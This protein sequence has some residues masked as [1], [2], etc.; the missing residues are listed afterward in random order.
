MHEIVDRIR[1]QWT[2]YQLEDIPEEAYQEEVKT[3]SEYK[4]YFK[5]IA[6]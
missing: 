4:Y 1:S 3:Q 2:L 6:L 5:F